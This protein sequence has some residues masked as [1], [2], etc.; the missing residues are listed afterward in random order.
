MAL[1]TIKARS[2]IRRQT[3]FRAA[4]PMLLLSRRTGYIDSKCFDR[5]G[6]SSNIVCENSSYI[7]E[8]QNIC[9]TI[10][11][12]ACCLF[13]VFAI[14]RVFVLLLLFVVVAGRLQLSV[15]KLAD[16]LNFSR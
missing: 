2:Y 6:V 11:G 9:G 16:V 5:I 7:Y 3:I 4:T 12:V 8:N 15:F 13:T 1:D 14:Y 10:R